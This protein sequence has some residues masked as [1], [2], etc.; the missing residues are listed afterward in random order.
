[1]KRKVV[2]IDDKSAVR[3]MIVRTLDWEKLNCE[4]AGQANNGSE[5]QRMIT[6]ISPDILITD[7]RLPGRNGFELAD[8]MKNHLPRAK[9]ILTADYRNFEYARQAISLKVHAY[10][11]KPLQKEEL[12]QAVHSA[13]KELQ[14][15]ENHASPEESSKPACAV[16]AQAVSPHVQLDGNG[17][18]M[19][20]L[21]RFSLIL[22]CSS[23]MDLQQNLSS[24]LTRL[25]EYSN[26]FP[27][28]WRGMVGKAAIAV[29]E[30]YYKSTR[31]EYGLGRSIY[32]LLCEI[33]QLNDLEEAGI[34]LTRLISDMQQKLASD[35][36]SYSPI[37]KQIIDYINGQYN[38]N[39]NL[40][41]VADYFGVS[42][43]Y[44]S[45]TIYAATGVHFTD[46]V[47]RTRIEVAKQLLKN[48]K[49]K[50]N[51][52]GDMVG[53]SNY[54]YFYQVFKRVEGISPK[55]FKNQQV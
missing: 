42:Q 7:I 21:E 25:Y 1:M 52:V 3:N 26:G 5:G 41:S 13:I 35:G 39:I 28:V 9:T 18:I 12:Y 51:E 6:H 8:W 17:P 33:D 37:V 53:F 20:D 48:A 4:V 46:L 49:Y 11:I 32:Q 14:P 27:A 19:Q 50:V 30:H 45:R 36:R 47:S 2:V 16:N 54:S 23:E 44:V 15:C 43:S 34:F 10:V 55:E 22:D 38:R 31:D 40:A 29:V 24:F